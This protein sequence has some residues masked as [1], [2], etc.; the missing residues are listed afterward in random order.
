MIVVY[1][2][3]SNRRDKKYKVMVNGITIH[4]GQ[5]GYKDYTI[6][7]DTKRKSNYISR[8]SL[9]EDWTVKGINKAGFWSRWLLWNKPTLNESIKDIENKFNIILHH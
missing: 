5:Y 3:K 2:E 7:K 6:H 9:K 4:F 1:L 8:H